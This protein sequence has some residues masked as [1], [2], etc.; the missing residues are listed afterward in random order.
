MHECSIST[1]YYAI[2]VNNH[3]LVAISSKQLQLY[4]YVIKILYGLVYK[5]KIEF[6]N[7]SLLILHTVH[8]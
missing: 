4:F 7:G 2:I 6:L 5:V 8:V 1:L 3:L